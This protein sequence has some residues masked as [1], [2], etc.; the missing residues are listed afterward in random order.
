MSGKLTKKHDLLV[1]YVARH[2]KQRFYDDVRAR[3]EGFRPPARVEHGLEAPP[4][5]PDVT[6]VARGAKLNVLEVETP[7]TLRRAETARK[8]AALAHHAEQRGGRFWVVVPRGTSESARKKLHSAAV[9]AQL[10]EVAA[11]AR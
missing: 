10:W 9:N 8:W 6:M 7:E 11:E 5:V 4:V 3:A 2:L 1:E